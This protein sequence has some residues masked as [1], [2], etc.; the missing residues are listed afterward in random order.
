[1]R[2][3]NGNL[4][5]TIFSSAMAG[6]ICAASPTTGAEKT[7][8][9]ASS[10]Q[11]TKEEFPPIA[12]T[13]VIPQ[14]EKTLSKPAPK[15]TPNERYSPPMMITTKPPAVPIMPPTRSTSYLPSPP[16]APLKPIEPSDLTLRVKASSD[17]KILFIAG[18]FS[19]GTFNKVK[20]VLNTSP[21]VKT[22]AI[23]SSGGIVFEGLLLSHII[24]ERKLNTYAGSLCASACTMA[25]LGGTERVASTK[26]KIGFHRSRLDGAASIFSTPKSIES[27][28]SAGD[29]LIRSAYM[30]AGIDTGFIKRALTTPSSTMWYPNEAELAL[31][32]VTTR[33]SKGE[34][35]S[36]PY[37]MGDNRAQIEKLM[38]AEP[39]WQETAKH[40]PV[41][42]VESVNSAWRSFNYGSSERQ[43]ILAARSQLNALLLKKANELPDVVLEN[44]ATHLSSL[45]VKKDSF[46]DFCYAS[47]TQ[48]SFF[49]NNLPA[50]DIAIGNA[51]TLSMITAPLGPVAMTRD[52]AYAAAMN[53]KARLIALD[54]IVHS[55]VDARTCNVTQKIIREIALLPKSERAKTMRALIILDLGLML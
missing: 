43:A 24:R 30:Q 29:S 48:T 14:T 55:E 49:M 34:E 5:F 45:T 21:N 33:K 50:Q 25:F 51:V 31:A 12:P 47:I 15:S 28:E 3:K 38:I 40:A 20:R 16:P 10:S 46:T 22:V 2:F 23:T 19:N 42:F 6:L 4:V 26:A 41:Q 32:R 44:Y 52:E 8:V 54:K 35:I 9:L 53:F 18:D 17:G 7:S 27:A 37:E 36:I 13:M 39:F 1:M 11:I